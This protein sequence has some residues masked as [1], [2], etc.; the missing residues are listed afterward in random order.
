M[1]LCTTINQSFY[2]FDHFDHVY[3]ATGFKIPMTILSVLCLFIGNPM[4]M[5]LIH[6]ER[7]GGDPKKR[8]VSN[9]LLSVICCLLVWT[10]TS[11]C[12][13]LTWRSYIG[14]L[15]KSLVIAH[16]I[17]KSWSTL[18][19]VL[20]VIQILMQKMLELYTV[21]FSFQIDEDWLSIFLSISSFIVAAMIETL[22]L[23][24]GS[25]IDYDFRLY[26]GT[27]IWLHPNVKYG[28]HIHNIDKG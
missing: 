3:S 28:I 1:E 9:Q 12:L 6:F 19:L 23:H 15:N 18:T 26:T 14:P 2:T 11:N 25:G 27:P 5:G 8:S 16:L 4:Y 13:L 17:T 20:L 10:A 7:F 21:Q 24:A 22:K